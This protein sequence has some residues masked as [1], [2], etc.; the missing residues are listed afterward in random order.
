M[1]S[2]RR[3]VLSEAIATPDGGRAL[4]GDQRLHNDLLGRSLSLSLS[5]SLTHTPFNTPVFFVML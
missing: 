2:S 5:L 3:L 4:R 1:Q